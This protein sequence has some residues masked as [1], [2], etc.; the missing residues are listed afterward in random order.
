MG[1]KTLEAIQSTTPPKPMPDPDIPADYPDLQLD[2]KKK[3]GSKGQTVKLIQ[4]WLC[5]HGFKVVVDGGYG[6]ATGAQVRHFQRAKGLRPSGVVDD[7]TWRALIR[8]MLMAISPIAGNRPLGQLVLAYAR[9]HPRSIRSRRAGRT[10]GLGAP[11]HAGTRGRRLPWCA[12][13]LD[14]LP[15]AGVLD[16]GVA[17]PIRR[18]LSCDDMARQRAAGSAQPPPSQRA[19]ITPG[20]FF[21]RLATHGEGFEYATPGSSSGRRRH[22][23]D[24]RGNLERLERV[25]GGLDDDA[26]VPVLERLAVRREP[27]EEAA[28]RDARAL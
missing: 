4:G 9:Q 17:P 10:Q 22:V 28:R 11:L 15:L 14:V 25:G 20:S 13:L 3:V 7:A 19:R 8:P 24:D 12:G 21:L 6:K 23:Q 16:V 5:Y 2:A 26:G 1:A 18:T 27:E